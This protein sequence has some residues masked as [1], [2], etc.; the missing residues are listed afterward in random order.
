MTQKQRKAMSTLLVKC[1]HTT[2][3]HSRALNLKLKWMCL[4]LFACIKTIRF[5]KISAV[6]LCN[7][8]KFW[9]GNSVRW[10]M[11]VFLS[12]TL[13]M[14]HFYT[15]T[16]IFFIWGLF[17]V[18]FLLDSYRMNWERRW[19]AISRLPDLLIIVETKWNEVCIMATASESGNEGEKSSNNKATTVKLNVASANNNR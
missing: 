14:L 18:S 15:C 10:F 17:S 3:T 2:A 7:G 16:Y 1:M 8:T 6:S 11:S 9:T 5:N 13:S 12:E 19:R 4:S